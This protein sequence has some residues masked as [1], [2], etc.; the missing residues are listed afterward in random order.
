MYLRACD[1]DERLYCPF[2]GAASEVIDLI[3]DVPLS[4]LE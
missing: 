4:F 3:N 2:K 1:W